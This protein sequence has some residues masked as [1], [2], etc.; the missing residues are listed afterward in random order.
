MGQLL[1]QNIG[2]YDEKSG[3]SW[4]FRNLPNLGE[5]KNI[6]LLNRSLQFRIY[7]EA[8]DLIRSFLQP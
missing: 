2:F 6:F 8:M 4:I 3:I 7:F 5:S 1:A